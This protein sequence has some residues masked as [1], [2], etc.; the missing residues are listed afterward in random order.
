MKEHPTM[1]RIEESGLLPKI[2]K[3]MGETL[4][5]LLD[6]DNFD[7]KESL[8]LIRT[9]PGLEENIIKVLS[10]NAKFTR[11]IVLLEEAVNYLGI[12]NVRL[13][14]ISFIT[15]ILLP[16]EEGN[17][18]LFDSQKYWKHCL[19][20][21]IAASKIAKKTGLA[22]SSKIFTYGL[23]HD[24]GI[25][26][27]DICLPEELNE[28]NRKHLG[29][30]HQIIAERVVL[31]GVTHADIGM[32]LCEKWGLP[33]EICHAVGYH[34]NPFQSK[35]KNKDVLILHFGDLISTA[36]Y[37]SLIGVKNEF[38]FL[39][40]IKT[41]LELPTEYV[42]ELIEKLPEYIKQIEPVANVFF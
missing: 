35:I 2:P 18:K 37:E 26:V 9:I 12:N 23:I 17:A 40:R 3:S 19:G 25:T 24:I 15:R 13:I 41:E 10:I 6:T 30:M 42:E 1:I 29:G 34:H 8:A 21:A 32:W 31:G 20:T 28:I 27:L 16:N 14:L 38:I 39:E 7:I 33:E 11:K 4:H 36:Y 22:E 5:V